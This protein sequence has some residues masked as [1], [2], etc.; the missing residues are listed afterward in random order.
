MKKSKDWYEL[1]D[2]HN[3]QTNEHAFVIND[4]IYSIVDSLCDWKK[5]I[6]TCAYMY[7]SSGKINIIECVLNFGHQI[8]TIKMPRTQ[9]KSQYFYLS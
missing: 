2:A 5:G 3:N 7:V 9:I 1:H 8:G 6:D 4:F